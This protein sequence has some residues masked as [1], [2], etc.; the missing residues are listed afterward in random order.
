[1]T[2]VAS[3]APAASAS[4]LPFGTFQAELLPAP[5]PLRAAITAAYRRD[6]REAV[7]WLLQQVQGQQPWKDA[8]QQLAKKLVQQ[9]RE[10]RT[11]SSGV[12]ALMHEF[13][14]SS[15][16]GVALMCLAEALLRIPTAR[17]P[18]A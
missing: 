6:E 17:P 11:R 10:K 4:S 16:E 7:Q 9:V 3:A 1:M 15:E 13:S 5:S 14:L 2:T 12:D 8:T 18:I